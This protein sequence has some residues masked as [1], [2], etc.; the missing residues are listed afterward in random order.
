MIKLKGMTPGLVSVIIPT[1]KRSRNLKFAIN[2][3]LNQTYT[4]I[5]VI[6]VDD[7]ND[8]DE[9]RE[10][11]SQ[12]MKEFEQNP[13]V[14]YLKHH[15]NQN[16]SAARNTGILESSGEF[17]AF[18][19][20]DDLSMPD[21]ISKS[22][23][24]LKSSNNIVGAVC[25]NY[26]KRWK[27]YVYKSGQGANEYCNCYELLSKKAD[28]AP[29]STIMYKRTCIE[30]I[31]LYDVSYR[32]HQDWEYL[33]R[34]FRFY[35]LVV[36][37]DIEVIICPGVMGGRPNLE[38]VK[39]M[40]DKMFDDFSEDIS[41]LGHFKEKEIRKVQWMDIYLGYLKSRCYSKA[42]RFR[43]RYIYDL[44]IGM[45][46]AKVILQALIE[47]IF[48]KSLEIMYMILNFKNKQLRQYRN[49]LQ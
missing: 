47:G 11:T 49:V 37:D 36:I 13:K 10:A 28:L 9:Y 5:E 39:E 35:E 23:Q 19:D 41:S 24:Y 25:V 40:K 1:F 43:K 14:K 38:T 8:G 33:I 26:V 15:K 6:V 4:K 29:G 22:V 18:L 32:K 46:D 30:K 3:I 48:P 17:I 42:N 45:S 31:G 20:D 44:S 2:S 34:L 16:G 7:N 12:M 21:R 27:T